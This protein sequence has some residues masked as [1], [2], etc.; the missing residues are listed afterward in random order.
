M[1]QV[2][3]YEGAVLEFDKCISNHWVGETFAPNEKRARSNLTYKFK[4]Q[5]N[6]LPNAKITLPGKLTV[7]E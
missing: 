1:G 3:I 7:K 4:R 2:Y 6:R 5:N